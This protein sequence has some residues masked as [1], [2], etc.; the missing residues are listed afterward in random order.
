MREYTEPTPIDLQAFST[1]RIL[2]ESWEICTK[3][4]GALVMPMFILMIPG[5]IAAM[6]IDGKLGESI[7]NFV[8]GILMPIASMGINR[9]LIM[10]KRE[11]TTPTLGTT[12]DHGCD[13]WW[14][15]IRIGI[16]SGFYFL[17]LILVIIALI[18]PGALLLSQSGIAGG[19]LLTLGVVASI[20]LSIWFVTRASLAIPSMADSSLDAFPAF[21]AGW[22]IAK[23]NVAHT[24]T[25]VLA[26]GG[27]G[28]AAFLFVIIV[29]AITSAV[30]VAPGDGSGEAALGLL[31]FPALVLYAAGLTFAY[32]AINLTYQ[33]LKPAPTEETQ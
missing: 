3:Y 23:E 8:G 17:L 16:V 13:Y 4:F 30:F 31:L 20:W 9:S 28:F 24:R 7:G 2:K 12:F 21:A 32:V 5:V 26:L 1:G 18:L 33:A 15:G 25:V 11:G 27:L 14:R 10:L 22:K 6:I 19:F 29:I